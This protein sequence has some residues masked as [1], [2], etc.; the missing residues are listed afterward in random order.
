MIVAVLAGSSRSE[1]ARRYGVSQGWISRQMARYGEDGEAAFEP[2]S[3]RPHSSP[4]ATPT[5]RLAATAMAPIT[6]PRGACGTG[7]GGLTRVGGIGP[8]G[9]AMVLGEVADVARSASRHHT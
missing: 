2:R 3:R 5:R 1:V 8:V 9:A 6:W 7:T 4:T